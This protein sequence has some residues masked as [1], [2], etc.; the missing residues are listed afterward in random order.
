LSEGLTLAG[1]RILVT[2]ADSGIGFAFLELAAAEGAELAVLEH[3]DST[4]PDPPIV[5]S[6]RRHAADMAKHEVLADRTRAAIESLGGGV[7][8]L[9]AS[10]GVFVHEPALETGIDDWRAVLDVNLTGSF[11]VARECGRVM[12]AA[13]RGSIVLVSSQ[14][15]IVGH[16]RAAAYAASK[17]GLNGLT[18]ALALEL[19]ATVRVNAVAPGPIETPMTAAAR[20]DRER[21][22]AMTGSIPLGRFGTPAEVA[23]PIAFLLSDAASFVTGQVLCVDGGYTAA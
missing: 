4:P 7:D 14:I 20:A 2:G 17:A 6:S 11:V 16:P 23:A 8:G 18:R 3:P 13:G 19:A 22:Q 15:G 9:V 21:S 10:A 12:A 1:K 5:P